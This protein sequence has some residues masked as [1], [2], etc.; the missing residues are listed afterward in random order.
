M[1]PTS[2]RVASSPS[3]TTPRV[4]GIT[5]DLTDPSRLAEQVSS[6]HPPKPWPQNLN[7]NSKM[8][9]NFLMGTIIFQ[10]L[11]TL[12]DVSVLES[13]PWGMVT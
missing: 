4:K 3:V 13:R 2:E 10:N 11:S 1:L 5:A 12:S 7:N 8:M 6:A 9:F